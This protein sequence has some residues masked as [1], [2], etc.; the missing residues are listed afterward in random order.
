MP[1]ETLTNARENL[2]NVYT[3]VTAREIDFVS[4]FGSNWD[5]LRQILGVM[6][7]IRKAPGT[8]LVAYTASVTLESG[9]VPEGA[10]IPY[11]KYQLV[12][13]AH[14]DVTIE[15]Y[16]KAVPIEDVN[17][18]SVE[19]AIEKSDDAFLN[20]LQNVV[21]TRFYR[22]LNGDGE[23]HL[24]ATVGTWQQ[25]LAKA[26]GLVLNEFQKMRKTVT[27]VVGFAN[28]MDLYDH[29]GNSEITTQTAFGLTYIQNFMGYS[30][31]FLLSEQ[32]IASGTVIAVPVEN[33]NLYYVDPSDSGFAK[34]GLNYTTQGETN[35]IGFHA[36]GNYSTAVGESFAIMGMT[37]WAEYIN[38]IA[39]VNVGGDVHP[40]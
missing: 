14:D 24:T 30:T 35:L 19:N 16:A 9:E 25:A 4:R 39:I 40:V 13:A 28:I 7:P 20:E 5:A 11:S 22:F 10:V 31:L 37:L 12:E 23:E 17:K 8:R 3:D 21:L 36:N 32:D 26:K 29:L 15:K 38:G 2:P 34:L 27:N 33:I 1:V 6:R 18:Y